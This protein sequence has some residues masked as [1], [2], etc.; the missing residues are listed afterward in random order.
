[1]NTLLI[2][3]THFGIKQNSHTW[4]KF[5]SK[6][7]YEQ[8]I[9][10]IKE[11]NIKHIIHLGDV[12][13]SRA[14]ISTFIIQKTYEMFK[15]LASLVESIDI[16]AGNHDYYSPVSDDI[17]ALNVIFESIKNINIHSKA[18]CVDGVNLYVPWY[19]WLDENVRKNLSEIIE[20]NNIENI[21]THADIFN[22]DDKEFIKELE[23]N[24]F[25]GH[26]HTPKIKKG[27]FNLG[28]CYSLSFSDC[29]H[30]RG[31]YIYDGEHLERIVNNSSIN[32]WRIYNDEIFNENKWKPEDY[33]EI[34]I[35][36]KNLIR[37]IYLAE[38]E[39]LSKTYKNL[40]IIPQE[41]SNNVSTMEFGNYDILDITRNMIPEEL[42][43]KYEKVI[44]QISPAV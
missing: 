40:T 31:V 37:D 9:P 5:Q 16:I 3:D 23:C 11:K 39:K 25:S 6:F 30:S 1:M 42:R 21:F 18:I 17:C 32:F 22:P 35:S 43:E 33:I 7:I 13:D 28:S 8:I 10:L 26:M 4:F 41:D 2:T 14:T 24:I 20:D 12:F 29:N 38:I 44:S 15:E 27:M 19:Q 36:Q 34:Y